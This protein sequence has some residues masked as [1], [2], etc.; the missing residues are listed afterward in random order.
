MGGRIRGDG[1]HKQHLTEQVLLVN[2][3]LLAG[4]HPHGSLTHTQL[5]GY[6]GRPP[7][8]VY[9]EAEH[10]SDMTAACRYT[11][12]QSFKGSFVPSGVSI[13]L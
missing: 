2:P 8:A 12:R 4:N 10:Q 5:P 3:L 7:P 11:F 13:F 1:D 9:S 6:F